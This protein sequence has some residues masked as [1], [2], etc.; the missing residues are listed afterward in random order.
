MDNVIQGCPCPLSSPAPWAV[1]EVIFLLDCPRNL[2]LLT[3][4]CN[5]AKMLVCSKNMTTSTI[6]NVGTGRDNLDCAMWSKTYLSHVWLRFGSV[7]GFFE[8]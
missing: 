4:Q 3:G 2:S 7:H 5:F 6:G 1:E 8:V